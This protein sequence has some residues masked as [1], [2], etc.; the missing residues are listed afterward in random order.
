MIAFR[1][2]STVLLGLSI[3]FGAILKTVAA[4]NNDAGYFGELFVIIWGIL[5]RTFIIVAIWIV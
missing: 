1:I 5:W 3:I 4:R 2:I